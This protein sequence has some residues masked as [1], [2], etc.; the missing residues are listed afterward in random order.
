MSLLSTQGNTSLPN[1]SRNRLVSTYLSLVNILTR[2]ALIRISFSILEE[3]FT[4][5]RLAFCLS[6]PPVLSTALRGRNP[7][8]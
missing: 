1:R 8:S 3:T 7:Q 4:P 6:L 5:S 2:T